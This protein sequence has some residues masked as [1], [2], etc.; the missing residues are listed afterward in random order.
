[1]SKQ[2]PLRQL[3]EAHLDQ[4]L[5]TFVDDRRGEH[6][7]PPASWRAIAAEIRDRTG[8][9]VTHYTLRTWFA[10]EKSEAAA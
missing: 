7:R 2:T 5:E 9:Y 6:F 4:P 10:D 1:M 8:V 3:I